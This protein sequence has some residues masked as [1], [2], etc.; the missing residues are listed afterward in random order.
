MVA[1]ATDTTSEI[2][3]FIISRLCASYVT[4][5]HQI[6]QVHIVMFSMDPNGGELSQ[7]VIK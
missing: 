3:H 2:S 1:L 4:Y 6:I 5:L 7:T